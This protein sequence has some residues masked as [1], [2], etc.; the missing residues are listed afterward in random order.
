MAGMNKL[1][2]KF[3]CNIQLLPRKT[4]GQAVS[5]KGSIGQIYMLL[6]R[7]TND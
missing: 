5:P 1:V 4:D 2:K 7:I 6:I 3:A